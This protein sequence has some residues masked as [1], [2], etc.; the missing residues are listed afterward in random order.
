M[1][2][3]ALLISTNAN[4]TH[5]IGQTSCAGIRTTTLIVVADRLR[6]AATNAYVQMDT[7][8]TTVKMILKSAAAI[9]VVT[10]LPA[11]I[12]RYTA[13]W[14]STIVLVQPTAAG[15]VITPC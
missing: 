2:L 13:R 5:A 6:M 3:L 14:V 8:V 12:C 7:Q 15:R 9:R 1:D 4:Q 10:G 11:W